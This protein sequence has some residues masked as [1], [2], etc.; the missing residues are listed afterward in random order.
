M[1]SVVSSSPSSRLECEPSFSET[2]IMLRHDV[3]EIGYTHLTN[4]GY[5]DEMVFMQQIEK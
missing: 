3:L 2:D 5:F 4:P 1:N